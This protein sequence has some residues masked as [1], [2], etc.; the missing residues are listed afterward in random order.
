MLGCT[1]TRITATGA[2]VTGPL[3]LHWLTIAP[4]AVTTVLDLS[5][6]TAAGVTIWSWKDQSGD[7]VHINFGDRP[8]V[9]AKGIY[10]E[11]LTDITAVTFGHTIGT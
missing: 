6:G 10:V 7:G 5:D 3:R 9:F 4:N 2:A 8:M 11:T 1:T